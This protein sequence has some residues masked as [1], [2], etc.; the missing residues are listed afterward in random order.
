MKAL[1]GCCF[2]IV[3]TATLHAEDWSSFRGPR[4]NGITSTSTA[5]TNWDSE[6][7]VRWSVALPK[8]GNGSPIVAAGRVFVTSAED[9]EGHQRSHY[10]FD[11]ESGTQVWK[12]TVVLAKKMPTHKTNPYGGSTP[13]SD[14]RHVVVWHGTAG[15]FAYDVDGHELWSAD[16]GEFRHMWGYGSSPVIAGDRVI[17]HTGPGKRVFVAAFDLSSGRELWRHEEPVDGDGERNRD[18]Q[19]MGSWSTPV[20]IESKG[21]RVAV[22]ALA[23]RVCGFDV[24][25]GEL[26]WFCEG[27]SGERGDLAYSSPLIEGDLCV[28]MGGFKGPAMGFRIG[29]GGDITSSNRLWRDTQNPQSIGTGLLIDGYVYRV[30]AGPNLIECL[31]AKT[32][33]IVWQQRT[34][35]KA[36]WGSIAFD[37]R[38]AYVTD[39]GGTTVIFEPSPEGFREIASN[40]LSDTCNAT[41]ALAGDRIFIRTYGKLWCVDGKSAP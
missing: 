37:G 17:L 9:D 2:L 36:Y 16:L 18:G 1:L 27:L 32:G 23:T 30:G 20:L 29:S 38:R 24:D 12:Q 11:A 5:P 41:P 21:K 28:M 39:Q 14:G 4:G 8:G 35:S 7:G 25:S 19:Y 26:L 31:E 6:F 13:A 10:C 33:D 15:L 40:S 3:I 34:G 22:C